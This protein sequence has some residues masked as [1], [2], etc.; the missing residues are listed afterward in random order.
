[1]ILYSLAV[2]ISS[3]LH[4][5]W[6]GTA[7]EGGPG[8]AL[9][10]S[11]IWQPPAA[12]NLAVGID[13]ARLAAILVAYTL[14]AAGALLIL[15]PKQDE[16]DT[17]L[18]ADSLSVTVPTL[19]GIAGALAGILY[20]LL[21]TVVYAIPAPWFLFIGV[22]G[23]AL[24]AAG[25]YR[26]RHRTWSDTVCGGAATGFVAGSVTYTLT[27][28]TVEEMTYIHFIGGIFGGGI[29]GIVIGIAIAALLIVVVQTRAK[30]KKQ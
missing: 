29:L 6:R 14:M 30:F 20:A 16:L 27:V 17:E 28:L 12:A 7:V 11:P 9:S 24:W 4:V 2:F 21:L 5:P 26:F 22:P 13:V 15:R 19:Q 23:S 18:D 1:L 10:F 3:I 8:T 25:W